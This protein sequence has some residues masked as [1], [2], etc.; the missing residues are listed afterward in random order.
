M[1]ESLKSAATAPD[2][3]LTTKARATVAFRTFVTPV[4]HEG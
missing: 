3:R 1:K 2:F 4:G